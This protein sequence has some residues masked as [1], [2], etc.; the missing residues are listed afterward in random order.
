MI[1]Q[2]GQGRHL[3]ACG[4]AAALLGLGFVAGGC[5]NSNSP[6]TV[7]ST[8]NAQTSPPASSPASG[9]IQAGLVSGSV[10]SCIN[11]V[12]G[13][14]NLLVIEWSNSDS[15]PYLL[16]VSMRAEN[17]EVY[18]WNHKV[19]PGESV[20]TFRSNLAD[21]TPT[22]TGEASYYACDASNAVEAY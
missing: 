15:A 10:K 18:T 13:I 4:L 6:D 5:S 11:E 7:E 17:G 16:T 22:A 21:N 1:Q 9:R 8:A 14:Y 20:E 3:A 12:N 2:F 19:P